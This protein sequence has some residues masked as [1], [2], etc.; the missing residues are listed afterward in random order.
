MKKD[1]R[2]NRKQVEVLQDM[3]ARSLQGE[4]MENIAKSHGI[5]RKTLSLW[6]NTLHGIQLHKE[7]RLEHSRE[8]STSIFFDVL[9]AKMKGGN[10]QA[11]E[12]YAKIHDMFPS[13]KQ[14]I[15]METKESKIVEEGL[16]EDILKD[17]DALLE[18]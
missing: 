4:S 1:S 11:L 7:F 16:T 3:F 2:L 5:S 15:I 9:E 13:K 8:S 6:K 12:L 14:E 10:M 17:I 18:N